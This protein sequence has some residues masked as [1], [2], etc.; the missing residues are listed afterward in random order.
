[1]ANKLNNMKL[2]KSKDLDS[3]E[4]PPSIEAMMEEADATFQQNGI[5]VES[6]YEAKEGDKNPEKHR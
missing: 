6:K 2:S 4:M 1:M 5:V 3:F